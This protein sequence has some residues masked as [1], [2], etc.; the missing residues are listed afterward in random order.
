MRPEMRTFVLRIE[1]IDTAFDTK[2]YA[3][4]PQTFGRSRVFRGDY[5]APSDS[6]AT[7]SLEEIKQIPDEDPE[8]KPRRRQK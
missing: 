5:R 8:R 6:E 1:L 4:G 3:C 7:A 2:R